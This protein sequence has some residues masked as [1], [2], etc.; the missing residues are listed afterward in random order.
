MHLTY[1]EQQEELRRELA[2]YFS[3]LMTPEV[4]EE[5]AAGGGEMGRGDIYRRLVRQMGKDGWLGI[6][7]PIEY[8]GQ[9]RSMMEQLIFTDEALKAGAPVPFLTINTV[10][11]TIMHYGT[12][13]QRRQYLPGILS[14]EIHFS[15]GYTEPDA[16]TDLARL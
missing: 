11:P 2:E 16:G 7:W 3:R 14:G 4:E 15:I 9:G 12:E 10:G 1:T 5:M 13:E 8:G 6:G